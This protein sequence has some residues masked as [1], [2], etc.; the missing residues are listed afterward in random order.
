M[1]IEYIKYHG[2][3][4]QSRDL[5]LDR[6]ITIL[7][8]PPGSG[9]SSC[10][11]AIRFALG[12]GYR[13]IE[14][15]KRDFVRWGSDPTVQAQLRLDGSRVTIDASTKHYSMHTNGGIDCGMPKVT[16]APDAS[17]V[18]A[19]QTSLSELVLNIA[20]I[21]AELDVPAVLQ[22]YLQNADG[23]PLKSV[24]A[25]HASG[26]AATLKT[27]Q[28]QLTKRAKELS[29]RLPELDRLA[30]S[31]D[32][33]F[34][35]WETFSKRVDMF[36]AE[37]PRV[38]WQLA[39]APDPTG[40]A[41][42]WEQVSGERK[43]WEDRYRELTSKLESV[44]LEI[45]ERMREATLETCPSCDQQVLPKDVRVL[46]QSLAYT[47][48]NL[49]TWRKHE[50]PHPSLGDFGVTIPQ[51]MD[52][53]ATPYAEAQDRLAALKDEVRRIENDK[54]AM[55]KFADRL[56]TFSK[57]SLQDART[58]VEYWFNQ[59]T[60]S[61]PV[62]PRLHVSSD[63]WEL[64]LD[65]SGGSVLFASGGELAVAKIAL[66]VIVARSRDQ[67]CI[68]LLDDEDVAGFRGKYLTQFIQWV[69]TLVGQ[70]IVAL[71]SIPEDFPTDSSN[72]SVISFGNPPA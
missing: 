8:G 42:L 69:G 37:T 10:L 39:F 61:A 26:V 25:C 50:P 40:A 22:A 3:K 17:S 34:A 11:Q 46:R 21:N 41:K 68:C 38:P 30:Q 70:V 15:N 45:D 36:V 16:V 5:Q 47:K 9:K 24:R 12:D 1:T 60:S 33:F 35:R 13:F 29:A 44:D 32:D 56:R 48:R 52:A 53:D 51:E 14:V 6:R 49:E 67:P 27:K 20:G 2:I 31:A 62:Q 43:E 63:G 54:A 65:K 71:Q 4:G 23:S 7:T 66:A 72:V 28:M 55:K 18:F 58:G 57:T 59:L 19:K 64:E